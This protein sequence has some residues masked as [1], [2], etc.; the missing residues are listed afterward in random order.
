LV[1]VS[2]SPALYSKGNLSFLGFLVVVIS[3]GGFVLL[4][5]L[6]ASSAILLAIENVT[7]ETRGTSPLSQGKM[8]QKLPNEMPG[9][10]SPEP[11]KL[12]K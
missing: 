9:D 1:A 4:Q 5:V 8:K 3:G 7:S 12:T 6:A 11:D 10:D 2:Q